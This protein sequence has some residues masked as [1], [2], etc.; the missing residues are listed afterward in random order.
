MV[1]TK[2]FQMTNIFNRHLQII[3]AGK[4]DLESFYINLQCQKRL[5]YILRLEDFLNCKLDFRLVYFI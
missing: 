3:F 4:L 2:T 1:I 5:I